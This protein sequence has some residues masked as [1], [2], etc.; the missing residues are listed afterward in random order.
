MSLDSTWLKVLL[1]TCNRQT[2]LTS[3]LSLFCRRMETQFPRL[4]WISFRLSI[5]FDYHTMFKT[6]L[7][8]RSL[9]RPLWLQPR[10]SE[11]KTIQETA[12]LAKFTTIFNLIKKEEKLQN[13]RTIASTFGRPTIFDPL[14]IWQQNFFSQNLLTLKID[15]VPQHWFKSTFLCRKPAQIF[16]FYSDEILRKLQLSPG[17]RVMNLKI[18]ESGTM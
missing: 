5:I 18:N 15:M 11:E 9:S 2:S 14:N 8:S 3:N 16:N 4:I 6:V 10:C 12:S 7:P 17:I 13:G 1:K